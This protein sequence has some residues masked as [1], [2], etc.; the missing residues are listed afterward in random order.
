MILQSFR[1]KITSALVSEKEEIE[2]AQAILAVSGTHIWLFL[3]S[4]I[5]KWE[6]EKEKEKQNI[7]PEVY[8]L[9]FE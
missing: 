6:K 4:L 2:E 5:L 1:K 9:F 3:L 7:N 8:S